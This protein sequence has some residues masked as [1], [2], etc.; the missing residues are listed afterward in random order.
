MLV[1]LLKT[2]PAQS[3]KKLRYLLEPLVTG[4]VI[5]IIASARLGNKQFP[6]LC[7][8]FLTLYHIEQESSDVI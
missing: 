8:I 6:A 1:T 3:Y 7:V 2:L 5:L 4:L